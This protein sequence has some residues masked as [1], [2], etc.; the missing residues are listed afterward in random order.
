MPPPKTDKAFSNKIASN[1]KN[2]F[3]LEGEAYIIK[4][5]DRCGQYPLPLVVRGPAL[6]RTDI[7]LKYLHL[8]YL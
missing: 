3:E 4:Q 1:W 6:S 8:L 5:A 2:T 7:T